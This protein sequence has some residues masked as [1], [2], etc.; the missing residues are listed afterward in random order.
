MDMNLKRKRHK[1]EE[2]NEEQQQNWKE[3]EC[4]EKLMGTINKEVSID[5]PKL[6][7]FPSY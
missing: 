7:M 1:K 5:A 2:V 4:S 3:K 6:W